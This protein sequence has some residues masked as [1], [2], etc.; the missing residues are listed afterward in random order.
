LA[1][2]E[3]PLRPYGVV[4]P[5]NCQQVP[6]SGWVGPRTVWSSSRSSSVRRFSG[7]GA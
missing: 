2:A 6:S 1:L 7:P 4:V 5:V 3:P